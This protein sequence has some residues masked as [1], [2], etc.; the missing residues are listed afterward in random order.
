MV[1]QI[2][3]K[4]RKDKKISQTKLAKLLFID[5]TTLSGWERGYRES[6]FDSIEKIAT[7]CDYEIQ[8]INKSSKGVI[9]SKNIDRKID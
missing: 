9:N 4:I 3:K 2:L 7:I 5:Q 1:G 6:T 8:F